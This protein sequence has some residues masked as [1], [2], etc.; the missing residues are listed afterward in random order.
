MVDIRLERKSKLK[1][2]GRKHSKKGVAAMFLA[3]LSFG[4]LAAASVLSAIAKGQAGV[5]VGYLG[6]G[7]LFVALVGF[8]LGVFS[9]REPDIL[10]FQPVFGVT[11]NG[12][13]LL[14]LV[15]LYLTGMMV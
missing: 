5:L 1:F 6:I 12:I 4:G 3:L 13:L 15:S 14:A 7:C 8:I 9:L 2:Q 11:V 10:Y